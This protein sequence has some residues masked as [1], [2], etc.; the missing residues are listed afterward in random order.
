MQLPPLTLML[1]NSF[2]SPS[3]RCREASEPRLRS[4]EGLG[5]IGDQSRP[6]KGPRRERSFVIHAQTLKTLMIVT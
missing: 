5:T 6:Q 1:R 3:G 2:A 4:D